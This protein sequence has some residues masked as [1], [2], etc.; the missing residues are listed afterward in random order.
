[1]DEVASA[2]INPYVPYSAASF[3]EHQVS[4]FQVFLRDIFS[5]FC[6]KIRRP[7]DFSGE[8]ISISN[9]YKTRA[10]NASFAEAAEP[11]GGSVPAAEMFSQPFLGSG[12][13]L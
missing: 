4:K 13:F 5:G 8:D 2:Y 12:L 7:W 11:V 6:K 10:I 3:E 1:M 9:L